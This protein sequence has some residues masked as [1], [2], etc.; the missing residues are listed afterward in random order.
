[1]K[2]FKVLNNI[3]LSDIDPYYTGNDDSI[4]TYGE[5]S[6]YTKNETYSD[7]YIFSENFS[8]KLTYELEESPN[9]LII[10]EE[11]LPDMNNIGYS[12]CDDTIWLDFKKDYVSVFELSEQCKGLD[13]IH[14]DNEKEIIIIPK[15]SKPSL[16]LINAKLIINNP[17]LKEELIEAGFNN[18][19][20]IEKSNYQ[21][22]DLILEQYIS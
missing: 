15:G 4:R 21:D 14:I 17:N 22:I 13:Y 19:N 11:A 6:Y 20:N 16:N 3:K 5:G 8:I 12:D 9:S 1:M 10:D 18:F 7:D 2:I